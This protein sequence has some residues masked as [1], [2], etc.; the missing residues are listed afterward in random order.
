MDPNNSKTV[1]RANTPPPPYDEG[2][3]I[4]PA[5]LVFSNDY[6]MHH[7]NFAPECIIESTLGPMPVR[8]FCP[9]CHNY[10][11]TETDESPSNEAYLC[12][13]LIF[14]VGYKKYF[15]PT[16]PHYGLDLNTPLSNIIISIEIN[17]HEYNIQ[18][19]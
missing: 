15:P 14:I 16:P 8:M 2:P 11:I 3:G 6:T 12:C 5:G 19:Y 4:Y 18:Y 10:I 9:T 17:I 1:P 13:M 7:Q